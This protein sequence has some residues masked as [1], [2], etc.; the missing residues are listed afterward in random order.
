[1]G[2]QVSQ[3]HLVVHHRVDLGPHLSHFREDYFGLGD[4][5]GVSSIEAFRFRQQGTKRVEPLHR[6]EE[7]GPAFLLRF[8]HGFC[9][10]G[11]G[12]VGLFAARACGDKRNRIDSAIMVRTFFS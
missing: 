4:S 6:G 7:I 12:R 5:C 10:D 9:P 11:S 2:L 8:H 3:F 1:M